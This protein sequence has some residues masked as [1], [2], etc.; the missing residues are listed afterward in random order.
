MNLPPYFAK[1]SFQ[2]APCDSC[3]VSAM[4]GLGIGLGSYPSI[5]H[6]NASNRICRLM[7]ADGSR[8]KLFCQ[9]G[10]VVVDYSVLICPCLSGDACAENSAHIFS[11]GISDVAASLLEHFQ[12]PSTALFI[13]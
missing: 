11:S 6:K 3:A 2:L 7:W 4:H 1:T 10:E 13:Q 8:A 9:A 5:R 12:H